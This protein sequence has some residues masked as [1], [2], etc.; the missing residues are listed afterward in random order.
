MPYKTKK[1]VILAFIILV[2]LK[3]I[4]TFIRTSTRTII[5]VSLKIIYESL[6]KI[7]LKTRSF[8]VQ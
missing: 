3:Y 1:I 6:N 7:K 5:I 2:P 8:F 4:N